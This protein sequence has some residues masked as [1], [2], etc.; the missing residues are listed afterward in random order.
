MQIVEAT[1]RK[2]VKI[3]FNNEKRAAEAQKKLFQNTYRY[4][5]NGFSLKFF[6]NEEIK[7]EGSLSLYEER[8]KNLFN[9]KIEV[10]KILDKAS[11][12]WV[13]NLTPYFIWSEMEL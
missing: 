4:Y 6:T 10:T 8:V 5:Y 1:G 12:L 11:V 9:I 2:W 3:N 7:D 13:D